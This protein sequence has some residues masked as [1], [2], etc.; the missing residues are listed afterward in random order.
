MEKNW[1]Q[2]YI[3]GE[4]WQISGLGH[5]TLEDQEQSFMGLRFVLVPRIRAAVAT[6]GVKIVANASEQKS[7]IEVRVSFYNNFWVG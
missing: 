4:K 5:S 3:Y 7:D 1:A 6:V 2:K